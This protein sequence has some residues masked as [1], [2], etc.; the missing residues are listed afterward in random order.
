MKRCKFS[1]RLFWFL[2]VIVFPLTLSA[3]KII[4]NPGTPGITQSYIYDDFELIEGV[5]VADIDFWQEWIDGSYSRRRVI[6]LKK[7][8][9]RGRAEVVFYEPS[10]K[11]D[12]RVTIVE[13]K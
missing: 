8:S 11:Y 3:A 5:E 12:I 2:Q 9:T 10:A 6:Q 1:L 4:E 13:P 7:G